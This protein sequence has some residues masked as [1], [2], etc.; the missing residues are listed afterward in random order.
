MRGGEWGLSGVACCACVCAHAHAGGMETCVQNACVCVCVFVRGGV[1][2]S[3]TSRFDEPA[4]HVRAFGTYTDTQPPIA[5][6]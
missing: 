6:R 1:R 5:L 3:E 4:G 2:T